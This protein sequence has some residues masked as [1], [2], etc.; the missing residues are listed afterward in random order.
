MFP[1]GYLLEERIGCGVEAASKKRVL[2]Q[3]G[4]RLAESVPNLSQDQVFDALLERE[5][6]GS[7][8]LGKGI[9]LPHARM[10]QI[11][12]AVAA[13]VQLPQGIDFDAI[14]NQP[15]DLAFAMLV[16]EEATDEHLQL[17]AKLARMFDDG[18][19]CATLREAETAH[20]LLLLIEQREAAISA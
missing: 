4:Q 13:F 2:E 7:T 14:D 15:V 10:P 20:D 5:R 16:P 9:A 12:Q 3:L 1:E 11:S 8:G 19:F 17:L 6:L 18:D